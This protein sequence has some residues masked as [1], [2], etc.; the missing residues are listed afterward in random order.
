MD[1]DTIAA[2][3]AKLEEAIAKIEGSFEI[4]D[5]SSPPPL[6]IE[7]VEEASPEPVELPVTEAPELAPPEIEVPVA[8]PEAL[9][10]NEDPL[11]AR[12]RNRYRRHR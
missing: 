12:S 1:D 2:E 7:K 8:E 10:S 11:A 3:L 4:G 9:L 5:V 6:P